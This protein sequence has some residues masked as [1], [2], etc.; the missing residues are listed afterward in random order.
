MS[1]KYSSDDGMQKLFES[2]RKNTNEAFA[3]NSAR[4]M[5]SVEEQLNPQAMVFPSG[6]LRL[7]LMIGGETFS[8]TAKLDPVDAEEILSLGA[9]GMMEAKHE[10]KEEDKEDK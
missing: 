2:F 5:G 8:T 9:G 4:P 10:D 7:D 3:P 6:E 1:N